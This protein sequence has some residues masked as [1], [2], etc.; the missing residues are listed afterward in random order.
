[1][2]NS[3]NTSSQKKRR[4]RKRKLKHR[5]E[6]ATVGFGLSP[7]KVFLSLLLLVALGGLIYYVVFAKVPGSETVAKSPSEM[8]LQKTELTV[9]QRLS[10]MSS[11]KPSSDKSFLATID[12][13]VDFENELEILESKPGLTEQQKSKIELLHVRNQSI[14][15]MTMVRNKV[16]CE[17]EKAKLFRYCTQRIDS[18]D[19]QLKEN[20]RYWLCIIPTIEFAENPSDETYR[21]FAAALT[22]YPDGY[23]KSPVSAAVLC[24]LLV[25]MS[26]GGSFKKEFARKGYSLLIEQL[27]KSK[28]KS[29]HDIGNKMQ[30]YANFGEYDLK[31]LGDRLRWSNPSGKRDLTGAFESLVANP[32]A[33]TQT[34][35]TLIRAYENLLSTDKIEETGAAWKKMWD[36]SSALPATKKKKLIQD[37]LDRQRTRAMSIGSPFDISGTTAADEKDIV[38]NKEFT[39]IV[40][41]DKSKGSM[42]ALFNLGKTIKEQQLN[43]LPIVAFENELTKED[44]SSLH[45]VPESVAIA[46]HK[47]AKK[48]FEAFPVDFFPYLLLIDKE[49]NVISANLGFDQVPNRIAAVK[50]AQRRKRAAMEAESETPALQK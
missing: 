48:Y 2:L 29:I 20:S 21:E 33:R 30:E 17:T 19:E 32:N 6:Q 45:M 36:L 12:E 7:M 23:L 13:M 10:R 11:F 15:V 34:W 49:G 42:N 4:K 1:M 26:K 24:E 50:S 18:T 31:T 35:V 37:I 47:T 43:Y 46:S 25:E 44:I 28:L 22:S 3:K 39:T 16:D 38:N 9:D 5:M 14:I 41:C 40:F 8:K 27:A